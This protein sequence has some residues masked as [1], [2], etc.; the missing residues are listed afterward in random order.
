MMHNEFDFRGM[1][2]LIGASGAFI[3][4][5][6]TLFMQV[7]SYL[8]ANR[9]DAKIAEIATAVNGNTDKLV[10]AASVVAYKAGHEDG[11]QENK[12]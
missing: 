8:R 11:K 6:G 3:V 10:T 12:E 4:S 9:R 7:A 5:V 2:E 1:S